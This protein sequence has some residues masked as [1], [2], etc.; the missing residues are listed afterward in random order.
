MAGADFSDRDS[1]FLGVSQVLPEV[2]LGLFKIATPLAQ[3]TKRR[4]QSIWSAQC[5]EALEQ[6]KNGELSTV[7]NSVFPSSKQCF[8]DY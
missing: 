4:V 5:Q 8:V 3:V 7:P 1:Q 6:L 2:Y